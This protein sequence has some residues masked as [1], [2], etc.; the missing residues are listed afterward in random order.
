MWIG[1][2]LIIVDWDDKKNQNCGYAVHGKK[3][4]GKRWQWKHVDNKHVSYALPILK[5]FVIVII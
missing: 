3:V 2:P 5:T 4:E 1:L